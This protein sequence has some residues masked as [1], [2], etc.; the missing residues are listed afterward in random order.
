MAFLMEK[1]PSST[2]NQSFPANLKYFINNNMEN[3][4][5]TR[6]QTKNNILRPVLTRIKEDLKFSIAVVF[7][8]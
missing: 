6:K 5:N 3:I 7:P 1:I 4:K 8:G 2:I